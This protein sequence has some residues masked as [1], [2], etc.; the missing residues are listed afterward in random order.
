MTADQKQIIDRAWN[1]LRTA[2]GVNVF[3][4][5]SSVWW[6][7]SRDVWN[8]LSPD[9]CDPRLTTLVLKV[10]DDLPPDSLEL[11]RLNSVGV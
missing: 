1:K 5:P 8:T 3:T 7:C 9:L 11:V 2:G 6:R 10:D 4:A